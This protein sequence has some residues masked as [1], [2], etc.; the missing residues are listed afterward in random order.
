MDKV[1]VLDSMRWLSGNIKEVVRFRY[2][3]EIQFESYQP[4][5]GEESVVVME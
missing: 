1:L 3:N 5:S 2:W 4:S